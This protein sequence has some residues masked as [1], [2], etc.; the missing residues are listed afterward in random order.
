VDLQHADLVRGGV[1]GTGAAGCIADGG[2]YVARWITE[3]PLAK[4]STKQMYRGLRR[5]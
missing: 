4:S 2:E 3:H 5:T 1:E